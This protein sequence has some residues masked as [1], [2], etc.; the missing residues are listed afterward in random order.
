[1]A[2][3]SKSDSAGKTKTESHSSIPAL[4]INTGAAVGAAAGAILGAVGGTL[5][6]LGASIAGPGIAVGGLLGI[7]VAYLARRPKHHE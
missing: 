4:E 7:A 6:G 3:K 1:M 2:E 5:L